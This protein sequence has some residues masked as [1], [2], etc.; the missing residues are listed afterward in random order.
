MKIGNKLIR[1]LKPQKKRKSARGAK[2]IYDEEAIKG[3]RKIW[4]KS[5][6]Y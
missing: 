1:A 4:R 6:L 2:R 3:L 5:K